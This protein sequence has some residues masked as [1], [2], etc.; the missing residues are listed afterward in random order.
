VFIHW[1]SWIK[2][3]WDS[4]QANWILELDLTLNLSLHLGSP[5][6]ELSPSFELYLKKS[7]PI[8]FPSKM[9][10][11]KFSLNLPLSSLG[12]SSKAHG[13]NLW[14]SSNRISLF[15]WALDLRPSSKAA[16][17]SGHLVKKHQEFLSKAQTGMDDNSFIRRS[18][19][20]AIFFV[21]F[22]AVPDS[23]GFPGRRVFSVSSRRRFRAPR[24]GIAMRQ[25]VLN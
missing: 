23:L 1:K 6:H 16:L 19:S 15:H 24:R 13:S 25:S 14:P 22:T 2:P 17:N 21:F 5:N 12:P 11:C 10:P 7:E 4:F 3:I 9:V 20:F 8:E 18:H